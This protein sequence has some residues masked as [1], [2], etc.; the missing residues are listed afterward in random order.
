MPAGERWTDDELLAALELYCRTPFGKQDEGTPAVVELARLIG[1]TPGAVAWRLGNFASVDPEEQARGVKGAPHGSAAGNRLFARFLREPDAVALEMAEAVA[2]LGGATAHQA[3]PDE[4]QPSGPTEREGTARVR[5]LQSFFRR[6]VLTDYE[7]QCA[8]CDVDVP[9]L[10]NAAH[11]IP[12]ARAEGR[13]ADPHNGLALCALHDRAFDR[14]IVTASNEYRIVVVGS[15][16]GGS[17]S[18]TIEATIRAMDGRPMRLARRFQ[19]DRAALAD[20]RAWAMSG[21]N[22]RA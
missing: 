3:E 10:L 8:M 7:W 20:H 15:R 6:T 17:S 5:L 2:R 13:R 14:G 9:A 18:R 22:G 12:W 4:R 21:G 1:R 16:L 19:A 11:I